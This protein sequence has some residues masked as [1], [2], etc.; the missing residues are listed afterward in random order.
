MGLF[1]TYYPKDNKA[2]MRLLGG[3]AS[4][5]I[6]NKHRPPW[7]SSWSALCLWSRMKIILF[8]ALICKCKILA[9]ETGNQKIL[10]LLKLEVISELK[11]VILFLLQI[12]E[13]NQAEVTYTLLLSY[14]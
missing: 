11:G 8:S 3:R 12:R 5:A 4:F 1:N 14:S 13:E 10:A 2:A 6:Y 9:L 7:D